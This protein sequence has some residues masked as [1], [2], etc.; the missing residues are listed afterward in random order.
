MDFVIERV[1]DEAGYFR[2]RRTLARRCGMTRTYVGGRRF[3]SGPQCSPGG[4]ST[5]PLGAQCVHTLGRCGGVAK[6][7][8]T[9]RRC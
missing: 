1:G 2:R 9:P 5:K 6:V 8:T 4:T 3:E 7:L